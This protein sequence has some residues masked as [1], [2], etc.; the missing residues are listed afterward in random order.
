MACSGFR[1][2]IQFSA[3]D[4]IDFALKGKMLHVIMSARAGFQLAISWWIAI[5][6]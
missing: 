2:M 5:V 1:P 3:K 4:L 6:C